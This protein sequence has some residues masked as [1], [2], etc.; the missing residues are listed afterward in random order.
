MYDYNFLIFSISIPAIL[1]SIALGIVTLF[2]S[3]LRSARKA[4]KIAPITAIRNSE[5]IKI[6]ANKV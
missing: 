4:S 1:V 6:K 5:E 2:L 3:S